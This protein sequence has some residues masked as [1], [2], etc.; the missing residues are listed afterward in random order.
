[1]TV[2]VPSFS[3]RRAREKKKN[4][5]TIPQTVFFLDSFPTCFSKNIRF[6]LRDLR[7]RRRRRRLRRRLDYENVRRDDVVLCM[8]TTP[9]SRPCR[10]RHVSTQHPTAC[11]FHCVRSRRGGA[12]SPCRRRPWEQT[13]RTTIGSS[14]TLGTREDRPRTSSPSPNRWS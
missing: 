7:R 4:E 10:A 6:P 11:A 14:T 12:V 13:T 1:M 5:N 2:G 9:S 3:E 8:R